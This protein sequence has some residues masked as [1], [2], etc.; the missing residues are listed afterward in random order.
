[1]RKRVLSTLLAMCMLLALL[2]VS[3]LAAE[4]EFVI[5]KNGVLLYYNGP[6]GDV[7]V[8][9]GVTRIGKGSN[10]RGGFCDCTSLTS[11]VLPDSVTFVSNFQNCTGLTTINIP[12]SV[13]EISPYTFQGC[14]G[15][16]SV[17]LG[18]SVTT[19]GSQ[20]FYGC[21][22]LT[23]VTIP[24]SVTFIGSDAFHKT[25]LTD[26]YYGGSKTQ[27]EAIR[28]VFWSKPSPY[29]INFHYNSSGP[30]AVH[31][32]DAG[33][34]TTK[35][36]CKQEGVMTYTCT[37]CGKTLEET[38]PKTGHTPGDAVKY[39][40]DSHRIKCLVCGEVISTE[41]CEYD[42][43]EVTREATCTATG[44]M[45]YTCTVCG[46]VKTEKVPQLDHTPGEPEL[47]Y[48]GTHRVKCLVCERTV[49]TDDCIYGAG[50]VTRR[51]TITDWGELTYTCTVCG[52]TK[53]DT[54]TRLDDPRDKFTDVAPDG[55]YLDAVAWAL[56]KKITTG[57]SDTAFSP[58]VTCTQGQIL[59]F[60]WRAKGEP[61]PTGAVSGDEYYAK[62]AQW[63]AEQGLTDDFSANADCTRAM[64]VTYLWRLAGSPKAASSSSF[65]DVPDTLADAVSWA[66][67]Q[68]I[69]T[70]TSETTFSPDITCTRGQIVTFLYRDM[71]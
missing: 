52:G 54:I 24:A 15:L 41:G 31:S 70:G 10:L 71:A 28:D 57:T 48:S 49:S 51:P 43:V 6:G 64:V 42:D 67:E 11:V 39:G 26:V 50:V 65:T 69:T 44:E 8:P 36:T 18:K 16:T 25:A 40:S 60:L 61:A 27:W 53:T 30:C 33:V 34:E 37:D 9:D 3:A 12:D 46:R 19:I 63:A 23:E 29:L 13:T 68:G 20:A 66:A 21:T 7:V 14:T 22:S 4:E 17:V 47:Y 1:M 35:A 2:P 55:F 62:P 32:Y 38:L 56:E 5:D 45:T 59:T 58:D